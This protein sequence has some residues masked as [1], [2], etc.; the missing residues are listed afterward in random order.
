MRCCYISSEINKLQSFWR[1]V[2]LSVIGTTGTVWLEEVLFC[3]PYCACCADQREGRRMDDIWLKRW[4]TVRLL[5]PPVVM[6]SRYAQCNHWRGP[7]P[8]PSVPGKGSWTAV[9]SQLRYQLSPL[10]AASA[11]LYLPIHARSQTFP[12]GNKLKL[13]WLD[14]CSVLTTRH[15]LLS[16]GPS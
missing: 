10:A 16:C 14:S 3:E 15:I 4:H 9:F 1:S 7:F 6:C 12:R 11:P 2:N 8:S 5:F 13:N